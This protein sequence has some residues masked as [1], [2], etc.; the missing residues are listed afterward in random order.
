MF[1]CQEL[2]HLRDEGIDASVEGLP[3]AKGFEALIG[4]SADVFYNTPGGVLTAA[5]QGKRLTIFF[6]GQRT[7]S[8]MLVVTLGKAARVQSVKELKGAT[9]GVVSL[10]APQHAALNVYLRKH[11]V[12]PAEVRV[13]AYG[14]GPQAIAALDHG[15]VDAGMINGSAFNLLKRRRLGIRVLVDP[16]TP[17]ATAELYGSRDYVNFSLMAT[18]EWLA[19]N[20]DTARKLVR[21]MKRTLAWVRAH[22]AEEVLAKMPSHLRSTEVEADIESVRMIIRGVSEDGRMPEGGPEILRQI[23]DVPMEKLREQGI[24]LADIYTNEFV[25]DPG[26][27]R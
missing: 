22:P 12:D 3:G 6:V 14:L 4:G 8:A 24:E 27:E 16:R 19:W 18:P 17:E 10:G 25:T 9:V 1:L 15:T 21:A 2:G 26:G 13:I 23:A 20:P 11:G 7:A 5:A